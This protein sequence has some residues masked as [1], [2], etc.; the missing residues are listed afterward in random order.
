VNLASVLRR[1]LALIRSRGTARIAASARIERRAVIRVEADAELE[2]GDGVRVG[3]GSQIIVRS[4][5]RVEIGDGAEI[6]ERVRIVALV[7]VTIGA[8]ASLGEMAAVM[9][10]APPGELVDVPLRLQTPH[11]EPIQIGSGA[12]VGAK[13]VIGAGTRIPDRGAVL[14]GT[15]VGRTV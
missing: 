11:A 15:A 2:I 8:G 12:Q 13:A 5:G 14:A 6:Q 9:D 10:F 3:R 7:D 4:G 1:R